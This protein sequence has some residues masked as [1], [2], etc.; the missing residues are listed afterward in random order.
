MIDKIK[1]FVIDRLIWLRGERNSALLRDSD[2]KRCCLGIY[3][4]ACGVADGLMV[5]TADPAELDEASK[6]TLCDAGGDWLFG[7]DEY[8]H[9]NSKATNDL[10]YANDTSMLSSEPQREKNIARIFAENGVTVTFIN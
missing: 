9:R 1:A 5:S 10:I 4:E 6:K 7:E 8:S 3:A 2:C